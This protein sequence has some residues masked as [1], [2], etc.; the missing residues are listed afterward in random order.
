MQS[1]ANQLTETGRMTTPNRY[2]SGV[3]TGKMNTAEACHDPFHRYGNRP[4]STFRFITFGWDAQHHRSLLRV[5]QKDPESTSDPQPCFKLEGHQ[6]ERTPTLFVLRDAFDGSLV[7]SWHP[8]VSIIHWING[9]MEPKC[10][11]IECDG[12]ITD[13]PLTEDQL[14]GFRQIR[15]EIS[16]EL[17]AELEEAGVSPATP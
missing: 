14:A 12:V 5:E 1:A 15:A 11:S 7:R 4:M 3:H 9:A 17:D 2:V 16:A 8:E 13:Y 6:S 10:F